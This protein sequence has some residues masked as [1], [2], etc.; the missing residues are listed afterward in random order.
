MTDKSKGGTAKTGAPDSNGKRP[1]PFERFED[2]TR[3]LVRVPK[4]EVQEAEAR[5]EKR[6][7]RT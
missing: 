3:K 4:R 7:R 2:L 6:Q 5:R 1:S